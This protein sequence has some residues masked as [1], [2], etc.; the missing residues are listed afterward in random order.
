M[1]TK[2][3]INIE[4]LEGFRFADDGNLYRLPY[5]KDKRSY[6]FRLIKM[7]YSNRWRINNEWY[8]KNQLRGNLIKDS[9]PM[10]IYSN[11]ETPF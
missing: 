2:H 1:F 4:G 9:N 6:G 5:T 8:S 7:Q 11:N 10:L 3:I